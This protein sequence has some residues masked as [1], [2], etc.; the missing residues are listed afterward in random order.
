[1]IFITDAFLKHVFGCN[2]QY[3]IDMNAWISEG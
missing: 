2:K 3:N 1:M